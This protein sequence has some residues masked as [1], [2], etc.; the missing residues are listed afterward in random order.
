MSTFLYPRWRGD[1]CEPPF[2]LTPLS[3]QHLFVGN[4]CVSFGTNSWVFIQF[5]RLTNGVKA[6]TRITKRSIRIRREHGLPLNRISMQNYCAGRRSYMN[7]LT[8]SSLEFRVAFCKLSFDRD[9]PFCRSNGTATPCSWTRTNAD[10]WRSS[11]KGTPWLSARWRRR[12]SATT[13]V[14]PRTGWGRRGPS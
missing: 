6:R 9:F 1:I 8:L 3:G 5:S 7:I 14:R 10:S 2:V 11:G 12:T 13:H 4:A